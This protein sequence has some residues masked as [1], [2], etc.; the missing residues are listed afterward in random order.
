MKHTISGFL[1]RVTYDFCP[2]VTVHFHFSG[3]MGQAS[4]D[5]HL[6]GPHSFEVDLP[7][8]FNPTAARIAAAEA[9]RD[10]LKAQFADDMRKIN[11]RI[12]KLQALTCEVTQ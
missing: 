4:P 8:D 11:E 10:K 2:D 7:D 5:W 12:S 1:Y 3:T 9:E 6:V